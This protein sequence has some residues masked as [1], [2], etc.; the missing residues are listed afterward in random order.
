M[1]AEVASAP[2]MDQM[3]SV[4]AQGSQVVQKKALDLMQTWGHAFKDQPEY[5]M[6][7]DTVATLRVMGHQFPPFNPQVAP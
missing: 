1:Q 6:V 3:K 2:F 7:P 5:R 4:I